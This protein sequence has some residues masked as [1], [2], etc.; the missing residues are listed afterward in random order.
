MIERIEIF[1]KYQRDFFSRENVG[2]KTKEFM[3]GYILAIQDIL[4]LIDYE[5]SNKNEI[6]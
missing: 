3:N 4:N 6:Y 2:K 5:R 1:C